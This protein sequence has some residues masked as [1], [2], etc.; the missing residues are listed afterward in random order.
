MRKLGISFVLGLAPVVSA[1]QTPAQSAVPVTLIKAADCWIRVPEM[2]SHL[3][4]F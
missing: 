3:P 4:P 2:S 1:V